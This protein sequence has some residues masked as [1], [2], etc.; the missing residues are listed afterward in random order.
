MKYKRSYNK[1]ILLIIIALTMGNVFDVNANII[2]NDGSVSPSCGSCH[3]G[4]CSRHGGCS[5]GYSGSS[6]SATSPVGSVAPTIR[7]K[8]DNNKI[9]LITIDGIKIPVKNSMIYKTLKTK[10]SISVT[11]ESNKAKASY[12]KSIS[13]KHGNNNQK[14]VV[15]SESGYQRTYYINIKKINDNTNLKEIKIDNQIVSLE[16]MKYETTNESINIKATPE[17]PYAKASY[18]SQII[19]KEHE[20]KVNIIIT[21]E[22]GDK[23]NYYFTVK[24]LSTN[25]NIG[26]IKIENKTVS[27]ENMS[28]QT[29][30]SSIDLKI[31]PEDPYAKAVYKEKIDLNPGDN[32]IPIIIISEAGEQQKYK[33]IVNYDDTLDKI[34]EGVLGVTMTAG[35]GT[36]AAFG[37]N[38][39]KKRKKRLTNSNEKISKESSANIA[40]YCG[41]CGKKNI[42]KS[43]FCGYCGKRID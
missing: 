26:K 11:L 30:S 12:N 43:H 18:K 34:I 10:A 23:K 21:A 9:K 32:E 24:K 16:D 19:L 33:I 35:A 25:N 6:S 36:A 15:T 29:S 2:C 41:Y 14:I 22:N 40:S 13:L 38:Y 20:T 7:K 4:C 17:D 28:Y 31:T 39:N 42:N 3:K 1:I 8:S 37:I 5:A 27:L